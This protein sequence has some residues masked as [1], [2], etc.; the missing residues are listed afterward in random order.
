MTLYLV[1]RRGRCTTA[2]GRDGVEV[3]TAWKARRRACE[4]VE[5]A[6]AANRAGAARGAGAAGGPGA[7]RARAR[8]AAPE[9]RARRRGDERALGGVARPGR[10]RRRRT[11]RRGR[12]G[13]DSVKESEE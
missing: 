8:G 2:N 7:A 1:A 3:T 9:Q 4:G 12:G 6:T 10:A 5:G 13:G 11:G